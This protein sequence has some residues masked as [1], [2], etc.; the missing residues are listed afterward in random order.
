MRSLSFAFL[1]GAVFISDLRITTRNTHLQ[2]EKVAVLVRYWLTRPRRIQAT[3]SYADTR[4]PPKSRLEAT[5]RGVNYVVVNNRCGS[6]AL[7]SLA[8]ESSAGGW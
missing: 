1:G 2:V 8:D 7:P 4:S 5:L 3:G 6:A